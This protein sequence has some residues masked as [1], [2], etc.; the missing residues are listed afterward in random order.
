MKK[1]KNKNKLNGDKSQLKLEF[2]SA[3]KKNCKI[4]SINHSENTR[5]QKITSLIIRNSKSF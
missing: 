3:E 5:N 4:I 1:K 2:S